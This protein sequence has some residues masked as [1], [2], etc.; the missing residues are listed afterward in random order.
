MTLE[1][2]SSSFSF[3]LWGGQWTKVVFVAL[4]LR[5]WQWQV[6]FGGISRHHFSALAPRYFVYYYRNSA[7]NL[8]VQPISKY[9][10]RVRSRSLSLTCGMMNPSA[11]MSPMISSDGSERISLNSRLG[12]PLCVKTTI[13][14]LSY[15][16]RCIHFQGLTYKNLL[17]QLGQTKV[18]KRLFW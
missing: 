16:P 13:Y 11:T 3:G 8:E 5:T 7:W 1:L 4:E 14:P 18:I 9:F 6:S 17:L 2:V 10:N 12:L 15:L